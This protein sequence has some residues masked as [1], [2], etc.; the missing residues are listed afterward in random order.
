N[1]NAPAAVMLS[2]SE[3][4]LDRY[5]G[6]A[7]YLQAKQRSFQGCRLAVVNRDDAATTAPAGMP[8]IH[9]GLDKPDGDAWGLQRIQNESWIVLGEQPV[10]AASELKIKG[11]HN[12][13]NV[14]A[15]LALVQAVGVAPQT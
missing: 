7:G 4:R 1:L 14:M 11:Q 3:D 2:R 8:V 10:I 12:L 15:A 5:G 9:L 6:I 13:A